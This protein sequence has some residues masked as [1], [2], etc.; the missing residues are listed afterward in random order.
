MEEIEDRIRKEIIYHS[1]NLNII[2]E[3]LKEYGIHYYIRI[4]NLKLMGT[5]F[6]K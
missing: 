2:I 5:F 3:K 1:I 6:E 4:E